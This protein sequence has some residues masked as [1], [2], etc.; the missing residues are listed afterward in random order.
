MVYIFFAHASLK[1]EV[2]AHVQVFV[3]LGEDEQAHRRLHMS[4]LVVSVGLEK[5]SEDDLYAILSTRRAQAVRCQI[6]NV[7]LTRDEFHKI[8]KPEVSWSI[9]TV[10]HMP[11]FC[12]SCRGACLMAYC[13][14]L[15]Y[16]IS[17]VDLPSETCS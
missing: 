8:S 15:V 4:N 9:Y 7:A 11:T 16:F 2:R 1:N 10:S 5:M 14:T 3:C 13:L 12:W 17:T 6:D